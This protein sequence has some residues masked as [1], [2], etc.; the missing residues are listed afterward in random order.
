[1]PDDIAHL[2]D[3]HRFQDGLPSEQPASDEDSLE[4]GKQPLEASEELKATYHDRDNYLRNVW[5]YEQRKA[6]KTNNA[7]LSELKKR[8]QEF[9][10]L[11]SESSLRNAV[12]AIA[13]HHNWPEL[14]GRSGRPKAS[15]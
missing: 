3:K 10:Y 2:A 12:K 11:E 8:G 13:L 4:E 5:M 14:K 15:N 1:M 6:G 7:I 9:A